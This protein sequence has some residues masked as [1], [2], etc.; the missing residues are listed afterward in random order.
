MKN[1]KMLFKCPGKHMADGI[2]FDYIIV[3]SSDV[4]LHPEW[5]TTLELANKPEAPKE[6]T[7]EDLE[8]KA[9]AHNIKV[10]GRWSDKR[11]S[12]EIAKATK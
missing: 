5:F 12:D 3:E 11:L 1:P 9:I 10:D 2:A 4:E 7:R 6:P 8:V